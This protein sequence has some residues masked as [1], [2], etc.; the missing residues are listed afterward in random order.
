M[1]VLALFALTLSIAETVWAS[2]CGPGMTM[3]HSAMAVA[4]PQEQSIG[5]DG[6]PG[7]PGMP[8]EGQS[9]TGGSEGDCP[10]APASPVQGCAAAASLPSHAARAPVSSPDGTASVFSDA[11][12]RDLLLET[13]LFHPPRA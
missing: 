8:A 2:M 11:M 6:L 5:H 1:G 9:E 4:M 13:A 12:H 7:I 10:F 3:D